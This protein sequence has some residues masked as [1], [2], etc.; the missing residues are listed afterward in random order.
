MKVQVA[1]L[2][3]RSLVDRVLNTRQFDAA[4][5]GLGGGD[6][7][8]NSEM[9]VWLSSGAMHLWNPNQKQPSTTWEREIDSLMQAQMTAIDAK[10]RKQL[11]EKFEAILAEN[12]P[13]IF[14]A[15]PDIVVVARKWIGNFS[16]AV[17]ADSALWNAAELFRRE[18]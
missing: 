14:L 8:P 16:P 13:F 11:Y 7:D 6:A 10:H 15:S 1:P 9:N 5:M 17:M 3:F 2:E 12:V 18:N 4:L